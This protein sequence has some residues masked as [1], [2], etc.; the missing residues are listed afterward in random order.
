MKQGKQT[1]KILKEIRSSIAQRNGIDFCPQPCSF[2]GN[3][4]V[5]VHNVKP[6]YA[7]WNDNLSYGVLQGKLSP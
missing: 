7:I 4:K 2:E 3:C 6:N 1:C 5:P